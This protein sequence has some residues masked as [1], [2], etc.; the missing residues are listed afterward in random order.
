M[1]VVLVGITWRGGVGW[2][3]AVWAWARSWRLKTHWDRGLALFI[4]ANLL[5]AFTW[6]LAPPTRFD[7]L[8]YHLVGPKLWVDAGRFI[9]LPGNHFFGFPQT[10]QHLYAAQM[11][12][13]AGRMNGAATLHAFY[14][15]LMLVAV[16]GFAVR[17]FGAQ[18]ALLTVAFLL[19]VT[20]LWLQMTWP[21]VDLAPV[22]FAAVSFIAL[23]QWRTAERARQARWLVLAGVM[24]GLVMSVK[25]TTVTWGVMGGLYILIY[26]WR[27]GLPRVV[28]PSSTLCCGGF[29]GGAALVA[30][31]LGL[32]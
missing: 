2:L 7:A 25:Y 27:Q 11:A 12:L 28:G 21:Y 9:S 4:G 18:P 6:S 3:G 14:G 5:L 15:L 26:G 19:S 24:A 31:H 30:A 22:A 29:A 16:G 10:V 23:D 1:V 13:L 8:T 17:R 20:S 32:L